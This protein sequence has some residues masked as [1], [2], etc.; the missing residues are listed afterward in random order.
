[1]TI[2]LPLELFDLLA[3]FLLFAALP[4]GVVY[5][6]F[7]GFPGHLG[8]K[9]IDLNV[10]L[11]KAYLTNL[12]P[13]A[14]LD[15]VLAD[16]AAITEENG[17]TAA[18]II[19]T[20]SEAGGTGTLGATDKT[21]TASGGSF[22]PFR[23]VPI[24]DDTPTSPADPLIAWWDYGSAITINSGESFTVDFGSSVFTLS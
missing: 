8:L 19:N 3:Y 7:E 16:L 17:Y 5:N 2:Q 6:K 11:I 15:D 12:A 18:D 23:Y 10:D 4:V 24:Y 20:Y 21:W 22:G 9:V 13:S 14:S 1:M